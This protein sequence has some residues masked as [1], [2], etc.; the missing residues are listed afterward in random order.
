MLPCYSNAKVMETNA[1]CVDDF[2][3]RLPYL[4]VLRAL[5][6][7]PAERRELLLGLR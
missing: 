1:Y 4:L 2:D 5:V 7:G 6:Y 3:V